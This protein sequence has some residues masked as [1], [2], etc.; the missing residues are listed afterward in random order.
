VNEPEVDSISPRGI[1]KPRR[2]WRSTPT[3]RSRRWWTA[4]SCSPNHEPSYSTSLGKSPSPACFRETKRARAEVTR[5]QLWDAAHFS[6]QLGTLVF[7]KILKL[8][9][10]MGEPDPRKIEEAITA[11]R[12]F[13]AVLNERLD[14]ASYIVGNALTVADLTVASSLMYAEQTNAPLGEFPHIQSWFSRMSDMD[15]WTKTNPQ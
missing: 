15:A 9:M 13:G 2:T 8:M 14:G 10:G 11:F 1:I 12:R 3:A 4:I 5:W 7:E 6:P